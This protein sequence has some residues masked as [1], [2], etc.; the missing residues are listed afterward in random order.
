MQLLLDRRANPNPRDNN[1]STPLH[2]SSWWKEGG[3]VATWESV[4]GT[5]LLLKYGAIID[6]EDNEGGTPL[7]L[8]L[9]HGRQD[10]ATCL[11]ARRYA[12]KWSTRRFVTD[13]ARYSHMY[14]TY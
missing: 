10:M 3:C 7:Q 12:V 9:E 11:S 13:A 14:L 4:E 5:R 8:V 1:G 2:H 6:N